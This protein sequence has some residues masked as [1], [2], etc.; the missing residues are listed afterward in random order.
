MR[1]NSRRVVLCAVV[2]FGV[3]GMGVA[4]QRAAPT[5]AS[6]ASS[7]LSSL[8]PE[9]RQKAVFPL[10]S[11]EWTR[12]HFIPVSQFPRHGLSLKEMTEAQQRRA[13]ELLR[14]S[15]SQTGYKTAAATMENETL[16]GTIEAADRAT[17]AAAGRGAGNIIPREPLNYFVSVFGE[18][19]AKA[20]WGW[21]LEGH[22][23]SLHFSVDN[24][25]MAVTSTPLFF[26]ANPAEVRQ[27]PQA[28]S[29]ILAAEE[30]TARALLAAL[31]PTQ[32]TT[33]IIAP[34]PPGDIATSTTVKVDLLTPPGLAAADM[35]PT[36]R[37]LLM[38]IVDV[39]LGMALPEVAADRMAKIKGAGTEKI[40]FVWAGSTEKG[41][42]Y[43]YRVQGPT[44]LIEHNN[45]QN[46]GNHVH[47]V[48]RDF[49]GDFG[50]DLLAEHM[51]AFPH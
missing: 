8:T 48:W 24:G 42:R 15:L 13:H 49:K 30:D 16:L 5:I 39:Y 50:R 46:N 19:S 2:V 51:A 9:Q 22:H 31:D 6:A 33:A 41:Q 7:F 18:P 23:V 35:T 45:T 4:R 47:S 40:S 27:G 1:L 28:G 26:G 11:D 3:V 32:R 10:M 43:H 44:F 14:V 38:K 36:Q 20:G 34:A 29:R 25:K 37:D 21:R 12:W 17:A